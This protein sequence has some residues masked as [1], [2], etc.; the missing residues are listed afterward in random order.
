MSFPEQIQSSLISLCQLFTACLQHYAL[1]C[2]TDGHFSQIIFGADLVRIH[3]FPSTSHCQLIIKQL[4]SF[5]EICGTY[6]KTL[7]FFVRDFF[8]D[9]S[10]TRMNIHERRMFLS[11]IYQKFLTLE[12]QRMNENLI[13]AEEMN[14]DALVGHILNTLPREIFDRKGVYQQLLSRLVQRMYYFRSLRK[15]H[16]SFMFLDNLSRIDDYLLYNQQ[17]SFVTLGSSIEQ[18][19]LIDG[20]LLP[21]HN[22]HKLLPSFMSN[23]HL[24]IVFLNLQSSEFDRSSNYSIIDHNQQFFSYDTHIYRQFIRQYLNEVNLIISSTCIN[25]SFLFEFHQMNINVIDAIDEQT[26]EFLLKV[27]QCSPCDR[28]ILPDDQIIDRVSTILLDRHVTID[29]Q[30]YIYLSSN[31]KFI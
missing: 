6:V 14:V 4:V 28:L 25:E 9:Q 18:S 20:I 30:L 3:R 27:Y 17:L 26:F 12:Y 2:N 24:T 16:F 31:G 19:R 13:D 23:K 10:F 7:A 15:K 21:I 11:N 29:Q 8:L 1:H 5:E 22:S